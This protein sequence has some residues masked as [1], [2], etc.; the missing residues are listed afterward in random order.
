MDLPLPA[1]ERGSPYIHPCLTPIQHFLYDIVQL[2]TITF[3]AL[4][5]VDMLNVCHQ[6]YGFG[7]LLI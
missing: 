7:A 3:M 2:H 4:Y 1:K 5:T 6:A